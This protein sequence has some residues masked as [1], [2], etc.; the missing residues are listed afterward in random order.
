MQAGIEPVVALLPALR[1]EDGTER[2]TVKTYYVEVKELIKCPCCNMQIE[3][4][5]NSHASKKH[6]RHVVEKFKPIKWEI[7][8]EEPARV[9]YRKYVGKYKVIC[10]YDPRWKS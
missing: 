4:V 2:E 9:V 8:R 7:V 1:D 5:T 10:P 3:P 6:H